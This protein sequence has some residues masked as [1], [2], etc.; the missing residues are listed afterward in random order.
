MG[1]G[2]K[3]HDGKIETIFELIRKIMIGKEKP[4]L[5]RRPIGFKTKGTAKK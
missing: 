1:F 4:R 3:M 2:I 5:P